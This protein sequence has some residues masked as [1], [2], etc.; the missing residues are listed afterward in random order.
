MLVLQTDGE[1]ISLSWA[2]EG[3]DIE[4]EGIVAIGPVADLLT[5]DIDTGMAHRPIEA[6]EYT[7][8]A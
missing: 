5:V 6:E 3:G 1:R 2:H 8:I 4:G 7:A